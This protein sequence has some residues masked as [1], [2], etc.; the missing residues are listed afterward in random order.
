M[1]RIGARSPLS[2]S[3]FHLLFLPFKLRVPGARREGRE[4]YALGITRNCTLSCAASK[5]LTPLRGDTTPLLVRTKSLSISRETKTASSWTGA[6]VCPPARGFA[7]SRVSFARQRAFSGWI[8]AGT[9]PCT[10]TQWCSQLSVHPEHSALL[11]TSLPLLF[12]LN[13]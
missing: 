12:E 3:L 2:L 13:C 5:I 10:L 1:A 6:P 9:D 8:Q 4:G 7:P 11:S